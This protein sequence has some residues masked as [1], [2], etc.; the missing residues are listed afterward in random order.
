MSLL[1][2]V[3][4]GDG[5]FYGTL[6]RAARGAL[7]LHIPVGPLTRPLFRLLYGA[8]VG[9]RETTSWLLRFLWY[10]PLLR[11]QCVSVG[12]GLHM[13]QL[14]Y[15]TGRGHMVLGERVRL[16]GKS[17]IGFSNRLR[18]APEFRVGDGSFIGHDCGFHIATA[19]TIGK[20][21][22]LAR[23]VRVYDFDGHPID[24]ARR[25]AG[26]SF[27]PDNSKPVVIGDDAWIGTGAIIVKGVTIGPRSIVAAG[28]VVT[29]DVPADV[30]VAGNP[31][32]VVKHLLPEE[33]SEP[34]GRDEYASSV[35]PSAAACSR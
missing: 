27:P 8:H 15:I 10:E 17:S 21:C 22:L 12:G 29:K 31:A 5:P 4:R 11:S 18:P 33:L 25:R 3:R 26:E 6:K 23:G 30:V 13:E 9:V 34:A 24:A 14:P 19:V 32:R 28:A 1:A 7:Q 35:R 16:S 20:H 2:K